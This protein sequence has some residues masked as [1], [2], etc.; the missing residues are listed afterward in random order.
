MEAATPF[1]P[2]EIWTVSP[3]EQQL[4]EP[5]YHALTEMNSKDPAQLIDSLQQ[6]VEHSEQGVTYA[7]LKGDDPGDYSSSEA[8]VSVQSVCKCR[9][10]QHARAR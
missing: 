5:I 9:H 7:L 8:L 1:L 4:E 10:T 3:G 2:D 6:R